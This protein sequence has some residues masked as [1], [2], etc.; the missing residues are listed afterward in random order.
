KLV[1]GVQTCALPIWHGACAA[2]D[3]SRPLHSGSSRSAT[4]A[5]HAE[6]ERDRA[7]GMRYRHRPIGG[8]QSRGPRVRDRPDDLVIPAMRQMPG[9]EIPAS[10]EHPEPAA[11]FWLRPL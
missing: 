6:D 7:A 4:E 1:T 5:A 9:G 10:P 11:A 3:S 8:R 2:A